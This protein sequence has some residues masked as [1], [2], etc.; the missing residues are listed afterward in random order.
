MADFTQSVLATV[1]GMSLEQV[2]QLSEEQLLELFMAPLPVPVF[3]IFDDGWLEPL[4]DAAGFPVADGWFTQ[5]WIN[6]WSPDH[7]ASTRHLG[8]CATRRP[9]PCIGRCRR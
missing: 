6:T 2:M 8:R 7:F 1:H 5:P 4:D 3:P 9:S